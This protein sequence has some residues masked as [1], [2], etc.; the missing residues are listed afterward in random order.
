[1]YPEIE[2]EQ[3]RSPVF[4]LGLNRTGTTFL[5]RILEASGSFGAPHA[6]DQSFLPKAEQ[7]AN[8]DAEA[9]RQRLVAIRDM[10]NEIVTRPLEGIHEVELG[11]AE[12][13]LCAHSVA[14]A[15]LEYDIMFHL[16]RYR[17]WLNAQSFDD[18][19]AEHRKW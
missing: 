19:Y 14:F 10:L 7:I 3:I 4:I 6:E 9:A 2:D 1:M 12:E 17:E 11:V 5:H 18:V 15:S 16:P 8:P 13:D